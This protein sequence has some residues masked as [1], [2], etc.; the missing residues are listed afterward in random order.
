[1]EGFFGRQVTRWL[2]EITGLRK[3]SKDQ[4]RLNCKPIGLGNL[5]ILHWRA[6]K[7]MARSHLGEGLW[8]DGDTGFARRASKDT[9]FDLNG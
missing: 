3:N 7:Y 2:A 9:S 8:I 6:P 5:Q 4:T 1:L